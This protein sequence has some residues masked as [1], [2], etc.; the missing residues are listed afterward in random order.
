VTSSGT[1]GTVNNAGNLALAATSVLQGPVTN[2]GTILATGN[3]NFSGGLTNNGLVNLASG[4]GQV[5][6]FSTLAGTGTYQMALGSS[7][8]ATGA[9]AGTLNFVLSGA[10]TAT[11]GTPTLLVDGAPGTVYSIGSVTGL[12]ATSGPYVQYLAQDPVAG[13]L[14]IVTAANPAL[15]EMAANLTLTELLL[16]NVVNRP[17]SPFT[18]LRTL[19]ERPC[20]GGG[21]ARGTIGQATV[22]GPSAAAAAVSNKNEAVYS[23]LQAS[24]DMGCYDGRYNGWSLV[25]GLSGG[26]NSGNSKQGI[27]AINPIAGVAGAQTG[28]I[29]TQ[30]R[31][32]YGGVYL[33]GRKDRFSGDVQVRYDS[34]SYDL[35]EAG[36]SVGLNGATTKTSAVT[37]GSR[38]AYTMPVGENGL[39]LTPQL[40][41][42]YTQ[43]K[44]GTLRFSD[45]ST[46]ELGDYES[47]VSFA[48]ASLARSFKPTANGTVQS[49]SI[50]A[51]YYSDS[52]GDR[53]SVFR[54]AAIPNGSDTI[55]TE[56]IG[57]FG[58]V[59]IGYTLF[60]ELPSTGAGQPSQMS[61]GVRADAR[62]GPKLSDAYSVTAQFRLTF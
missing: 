12:V 46:L 61:F 18:A 49:A 40:G 21:F 7:L 54:S 35:S 32:T 11:L 14:T 57:S 39:S 48:G 16:S 31:Q 2:T 62:S 29:S 28:T 34:T 23:G 55:R 41:F 30:F 47:L 10:T 24:Y 37:I 58:E 50:S 26:V 33:A 9:V 15:R 3:L 25:A 27:F 52:K 8:T 45:G 6:S 56:G 38:M 59:S 22:E 42:S 5:L 36:T 53:T 1:L 60:R 43:A 51:N 4:A 20:R 17:T 44:G 13:D 19:D